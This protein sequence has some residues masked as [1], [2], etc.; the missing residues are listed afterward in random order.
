MSAESAV[1]FFGGA[2]DCASLEPHP[3]R[4]STPPSHHPSPSF[5]PTSI[6]HGLLRRRRGLV[7]DGVHHFE[8]NNSILP[9]SSSTLDSIFRYDTEAQ[10]SIFASTVE[11]RPALLHQGAHLGRRFA[12]DGD[13]RA[14]RRNLRDHG[15]YAGQD[16][17]VQPDALR[18]GQLCA[19]VEG[20]ETRVNAQNE[21]YEYM[22]QYLDGSKSVGRLENVVGWLLA[23]G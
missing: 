18:H 15:P 2:S 14:L 10:R 17:R 6:Q 4:S 21:A 9:L 5:I 13:A 12:Q 16:R 11:E 22:V 3:R 8:L 23:S 7:L 20:T 1:T 19:A